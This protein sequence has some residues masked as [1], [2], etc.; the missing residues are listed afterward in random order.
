MAGQVGD[1]VHSCM[2]GREFEPVCHCRC[3]YMSQCGLSSLVAPAHACHV[4]REMA[5]ADEV[6][7]R[8]LGDVLSFPVQAALT[9]RKVVT[10]DGGST[11]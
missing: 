1:Q 3:Q 7:K 9:L 5:F 10:S 6:G 4:A 11:R 8:C 2:A